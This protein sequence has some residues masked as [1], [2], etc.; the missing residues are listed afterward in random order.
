MYALQVAIP[1]NWDGDLRQLAT[2][3]LLYMPTN[4]VQTLV[5][6]LRNV[7]SPF[8]AVTGEPGKLAQHIVPTSLVLITDPNNSTPT[9]PSGAAA[10]VTA[11]K[12]NSKRTDAIIGVCSA[13]AGIA[14]LAGIWWGL[15]Y[16]QKKQ[17][18]AHRRLSNLSDPNVSN[19]IYGTQHDDRRTS[20]FYAEDELRG[21]YEA[22]VVMTGETIMTQR[23]RNT[24]NPHTPISAPVL[25]GSSL[26]W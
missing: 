4:A 23:V 26:N 1:V 9:N 25:Q 16:W 12:S 21:G 18:A 22:P 2:Q 3:C 17:L 5:A 14:A 6:S 10:A 20:F 19:G 15:R 11:S 24:G 7:G 8:Y 13:V